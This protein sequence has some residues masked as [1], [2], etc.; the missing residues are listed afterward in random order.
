MRIDPPWLH[1]LD[2]QTLAK[3]FEKSGHEIRFVGGCVRDTLLKREVHELDIATTATPPETTAIIEK[4][5]MRAIP[6]GIEHG[7]I[8]ALVNGRT[9]EI[10]T[11]RKDISTD[12]RHAEVAYTDDWTEDAKRRDLTFNALYLSLD[13]TLHD[14]VG[15][16]DDLRQL[17]ARFIGDPLS[18]IREDHLRILRYFRFAA[19]LGSEFDDAALA[20]CQQEA[21]SISKLSGERITA[22]LLKLLASSRSSAVLEAMART[23]VLKVLFPD[24]DIG[25][26]FSLDHAGAPALV[27]LAALIGDAAKVKTVAARL[28]LSGRQAASVELWLKEQAKLSADMSESEQ[29]KMLRRLGREDHLHSVQLAGAL[30]GRDLTALL[31]Y[32]D[33]Q[34]PPFPIAAT[35]LMAR[36][37]KEGKALGDKLKELEQK[38]EESGYALSREQLLAFV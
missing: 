34:P 7:T 30:T 23:G 13:G 8:T 9:Y 14:P 15:G 32:I 22:E 29:K 37:Y 1:S 12:G 35:E 24:A 38:W 31:A 10:T 18:R 28:K 21:A 27:K 11:L 16:L 19:Q 17:R 5:G 26:I 2:V 3:A 36:G 4:A 33:W 20:A 6:T 25:A